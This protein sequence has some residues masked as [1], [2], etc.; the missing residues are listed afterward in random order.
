MVT[1]KMLKPYYIKADDD[2]VRVILAYQYFSVVINNKVYQFVPVEAKEIRINRRTQEIENINAKFAFQKGKDILFIA[3]E[4]L[5]S[6]PDFLVQLHAIGEPYY[7]YTKDKKRER[8]KESVVII[9][10]LECLNIKRLIDQAL[11]E[12]DEETFYS[13]A[14]LL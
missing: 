10:E 12:R 3:M 7:I 8:E 13:L 4:E 6:L 11:D 14:K 2:Y 1:V 5:I 9:D